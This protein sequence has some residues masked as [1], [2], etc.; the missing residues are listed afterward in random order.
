VTGSDEAPEPTAW[1]R[2]SKFYRRRPGLPWLI[3]LV[4]IPLLLSV[5]GYAELDRNRPQINGPTGALPTLNVPNPHGGAPKTPTMP[6]LSLSPVSIVRID[7]DI[8]LFGDLPSPEGK[9]SLLEALKA[10]F[11]P[12][13]NLVD[14][15]RINPDIISLDFSNAAAVFKAAAPV[16]DFGLAVKG[17]TITLTGT[18]GSG[19]QQN[20]IEQAANAAWPNLNIVD[21]MGANGPVTSSGPPSP[22]P[23]PNGAGHACANLS[24]DI[25]ALGPITFPTDGF[26]LTPADEQTLNHIADKLKAC[27]GAKV[28]INGYTDGTGNDAINVPLSVNRAA[29]VADYLIAQGVTGDQLTAKG[30]GSAGPVADNGGPDGQAKNRRVEIAVS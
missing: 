16:P 28:T 3:G 11:G 6:A 25:K 8:K 23:A 15:L 18:A 12:N 4:V 7:N 17:D 14:G 22:A 24:A 13:V 30:L 10:G 29:A 20:A 19:D 2:T 21:T 9:D 1:R 5:I 27:V 26:T